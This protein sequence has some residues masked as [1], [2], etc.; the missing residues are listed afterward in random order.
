MLG[1]P[2]IIWKMSLG[3]LIASESRFNKTGT[4]VTKKNRSI[5]CYE[6]T[7]VTT[8]LTSRTYIVNDDR[9][10]DYDIVGIHSDEYHYESARI[11]LNFTLRM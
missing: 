6:T 8:D 11:K 9:L 1:S 10:I 5:I 3:D 2:N 4:L 7:G